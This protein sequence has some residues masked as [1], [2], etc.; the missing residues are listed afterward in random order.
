MAYNIL[1]STETEA[2][3][4][5]SFMNKTSADEALRLWKHLNEK[6]GKIIPN[7]LAF[8]STKKNDCKIARMIQTEFTI[9][10]I[11]KQ[12]K[13][14][15][16]RPDFG[17]GTRGNRGQN[18]Q[19]TLFERNMEDALNDWIENKDDLSNNKYKD[20]I[21]D[22][23][24]HYKLDKCNEIKVVSEGRQNKKRPMKLVNDHWEIGDASPTKGY[25]IGA[26]VTDITLHTRCKNVKRKIYLS[27]KT[28]GT[29][30]LSNLGLKTTVFPVDEVKA[31]KIE[32]A[33]GKALMDTF[34][35]N[36]QF[37]C[38][39]FN[40]FQDGNRSYH[41]TDNSPSY[42]RE[43]LRELIKGSLG[44]GYHYVHLQRGTKIK[45]L[46]IDENFLRRASTPSNVKINY[47][48]D[49]GGRK[50]V[51]IHMET[52][53]F[54]MNFN[55][56]NTTDKGTAADPLRVYPDKLQSGYRMAGEEVSTKHRGDANEIAD[57][58]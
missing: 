10:D 39:T 7:P 57:D 23:V 9:K 4:A 13:I 48:G 11:K 53:V 18:N 29:T 2:R 49:T 19:G 28:T 46:E 50:R 1:P 56:R 44:Y 37:L 26:T 55:I 40:E 14:T 43:L 31:G 16:L 52:P 17:D 47:G 38:A 34:G 45:H 27:L 22:L 8:D 35:L 32:Q 25:N 33:D 42:D 36:E 51:N 41:Q 20:F 15:T 3:K 30:N 21:Y 54:T 58:S 24:K 12:L 6:Y 5:V